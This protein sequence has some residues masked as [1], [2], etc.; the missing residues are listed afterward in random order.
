MGNTETVI[1]Q[2]VHSLAVGYAAAQRP[3][4]KEIERLT[5]RLGTTTLLIDLAM[6]AL[7]DGRLPEARKYLELAEKS[8]R[9]GN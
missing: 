3:L 8:A 5:E 1:L 4:R 6:N 2:S 7:N 9:G